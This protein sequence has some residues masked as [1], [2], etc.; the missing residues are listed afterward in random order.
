M[1]AVDLK[2]SIL[3]VATT[4]GLIKQTANNAK[5]E[6]ANILLDVK[7]DKKY[8]YIPITEFPFSIPS[9]WLWVKL[10][11]ICIK[12]TDGTHKTP[13]YT[14]L[15]IPFVSVKDVS[16]G[17]ISF[18][19]TKFI[20]EFEHKKLYKRCNPERGDLLITKIG[21]TGV[22]AIVETD[23]EFSLFVSVALLKIN[24]QKIY[25]K[26]LYYI[27]QSPVVQKQVKENTRGV[28]NKNW[29]LEAIKNTVLP[30]PPLEEQYQIVDRIEELFAKLDEIKHIEEELEKIK[31]KFPEDI[32]KSVLNDFFSGNA[33]FIIESYDSWKSEML[34]NIADVCTGNSIPEIVKKNKY[35]NLEEGYNYIETKDLSFDHKFNYNNG[36]KIPYSESGFK[37]A[38]SNDIL[39]C[40]EGGS[41]GKKIG[42]L[43]EK[44]C[45]GNKLC[46]FSLNSDLVIPEFLYYYLQSEVFLKNFYEN[47]NGIIGGVSIN[48]IRKI[49]IKFPSV[50]EQQRI[51]DKL[52]QLLPLC[53]DIEKIVNQ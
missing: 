3:H 50:K 40:I 20:S 47:L 33:S 24:N 7:D 11:D 26:Y 5:D 16:F 51:V 1:I 36:I 39:M 23:V 46:K 13:K 18:K 14:D 17:K 12:I 8:Q 21:T 6:L 34:I 2:E 44:V 49:E 35:T 43:T 10:E 41:A 32:K 37:Y 15:G 38:N 9:N 30:L 42:I 52:E 4:G 48:K 29:V 27:L 31:S 45:Y 53:D 25:N 19:N 22:P 28:G